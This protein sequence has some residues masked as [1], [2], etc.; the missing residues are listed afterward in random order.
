MFAD[1]EMGVNEGVEGVD[2]VRFP[3]ACVSSDQPSVS[4]MGIF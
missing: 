3:C 1:V 2:V 4:S